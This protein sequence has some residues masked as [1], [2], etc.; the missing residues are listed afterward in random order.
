MNTFLY[1]WLGCFLIAALSLAL[2]MAAFFILTM[3]KKIDALGDKFYELFG[4]FF[5]STLLF[6][7]TIAV[8][9]AAVAFFASIHII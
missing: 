9:S 5:G 3:N 2:G 1:L 8:G 7:L 6:S 4:D